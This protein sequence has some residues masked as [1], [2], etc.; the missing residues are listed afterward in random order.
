[1][2]SKKELIRQ[3][4]LYVLKLN[5][6]IITLNL[7]FQYKKNHYF[8]ISLYKEEYCKLFIG[9]L[10]LFFLFKDS[11]EKIFLIYDLLKGAENYKKQ[12]PVIENDLFNLYIILL[13]SYKN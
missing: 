5:K 6:I 7:G 13:T 10:I 11:L 3:I 1:M 8:Y 12:L 2:K 9:Q 4:N